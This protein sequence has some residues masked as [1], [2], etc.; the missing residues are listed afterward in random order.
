M[1]G[2]TFS[3]FALLS[4][5][6]AV[7]AEDNK[8][9][10]AEVLWQLD[11]LGA[12]VIS[13]QGEHVVVPATSYE[14]ESD[15]SE[16]RLWLLDRGE[17]RDQRPISM[18]GASASSPAFSPDGSMLAFISKREEDDAGQVYLLPMDAPGEATRLTEVPTGVSALKWV[19]EHI[20]F[21]SSVWPGKT[22]DEM[23]EALEQ[24]EERQV[25]A[26]VWTEL[27]YAYFDTWLDAD[28]ENHLFRVPA[29]GGEVQPLS[30]PAG[31]AL[32]PSSPG[33]GDY[34][35]SPDGERLAIV[36]DSAEDGVYPDLDVY[37]VE[38]GGDDPQ[39]I[40]QGNAAPDTA[41]MFSPDGRLLAFTRQH[42]PGF[43]GDQRKLMLHELAT[44]RTRLLHGDW[45][46][47]ADGLV[48]APDSAG[49][50]GAIDDAGTRR[51]YFLPLSGAD[52]VALTDATNY[53][54]L[55]VADDGTLVA[56]NQSFVHP[57]RIVRVDVEGGEDERLETFND[58]ALAEVDM[59]TYESVTYTGA[60]G[61]EIQMWVHYPPG[62]DPDRKY[63]L[64]LLIHGG[65]HGAISDMFHFRWNAQTFSSWGY[66][67]AWHNFHGSSG[68]GQDFTD[69]INPDWMTRPY[70]DTIAA[71]E[72]FME[73]PWIDA[74]RMVAGGGSYG[75][76]LST[77]L[78]GRD[79]PFNALVIHA[80]VYDLYAQT[81][82]DFAVHDQRFGPYWETPEIYRTI[83]PHYFAGQFDTPSLII[84]GQKDLRVPVGQAFELFRTLQTRGVESRLVYYPDENHWVLKPNNSLHWYG[85][86]RDWV[87]RF[88]EPGPAQPASGTQDADSEP[89]GG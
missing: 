40:T 5:S 16:T 9:L 11:R 36:A 86:V 19:G 8:P 81:S 7:V 61:A 51:V 87:E 22:F 44:G 34:D 32:S 23:A 80:A 71:A 83:S 76:Y 77:V 47:S 21:I 31:L 73:K 43:Y 3:L 82:A 50:F 37:L 28:R 62:F 25:S 42:I 15:E 17:P 58:A 10:S 20:Y 64:F 4:C 55:A 66:V 74:E 85:E 63:P 39:N 70:A 38:T 13:P 56:R 27:P 12:P 89:E 14:V 48:W 24:D 84:H 79:H 54:A 41:P 45:D 53:D 69:A 1:K 65:P 30:Q 57:P 49:F 72:W 29:A 59:G 18:T 75:G 35:V 88:A 26:H 68:F 33:T 2:F 67:T 46:R 52:P 60:E 6:A 78:L